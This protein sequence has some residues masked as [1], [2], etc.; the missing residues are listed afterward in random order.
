MSKV[1]I[2]ILLFA[3]AVKPHSSLGQTPA[4]Q[5]GEDKVVSG[6]TEVI[7][8]AIVKDKKGRPVTNLT[9]NDFAVFEDG[10]RHCF[11]SLW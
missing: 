5:Q 1:I 10:V 4:T 7:F 2:V 8:D 9:V 6:T 3:L 11:R